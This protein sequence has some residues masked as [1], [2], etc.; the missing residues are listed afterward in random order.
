MTLPP[1]PNLRPQEER[2]RWVDDLLAIIAM[3]AEELHRLR[4]ENQALRDEVVR[5][6]GQKGAQ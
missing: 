1:M 2:P 4:E 6:K 3:Q 5:L